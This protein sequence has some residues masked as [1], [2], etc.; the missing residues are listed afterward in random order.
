MALTEY[1]SA[2]WVEPTMDGGQ[3]MIKAIGDDGLEYWL[4]GE[5]TTVIN[6]QGEEEV[7]TVAQYDVPP[8][9]AFVQTAAGK[10]MLSKMP[11]AKK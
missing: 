7:R 2:E 6:T 8:W 4:P 5:S 11:K 10:T 3:L 9:P 1:V